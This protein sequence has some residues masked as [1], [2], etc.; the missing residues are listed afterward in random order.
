M[1]S[2]CFADTNT[3]WGVTATGIIYKTTNGGLNWFFQNPAIG[4]GLVDIKFLNPNTGWVCGS[5]PNI[6]KTTNVGTNWTPYST[7]IQELIS[8]IEFADSLH[9][10]V[11]SS[12]GKIKYTSNGGVNWTQQISDTNYY[13]NHLSFPNQLTGYVLGTHSATPYNHDNI[14]LKTTTGGTVFVQNIGTEIP[15][16]FTLSQNYPNPF[17]PVTK[18]KFAVPLLRGVSEGRGVLA[19]LV[20]YDIL[21]REIATLVNEQLNPGTYE[22]E[23]DGSNYPSGV[24]FYKLSISDPSAS[25]GQGYFET[26]KMVLLK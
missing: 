21:G 14:L 23:W 12:L 2:I 7:G 5:T 4:S 26:K 11:S 1:Y 19:R 10:W 15:K 24:Y 13:F 18:I 20:I 25:S 8:S 16:S 6:Y 3:G 9:G 17:N 22:V